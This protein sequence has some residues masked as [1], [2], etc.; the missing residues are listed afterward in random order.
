MEL[1]FNRDC[2]SNFEKVMQIITD[3]QSVLK[4]MPPQFNGVILEQSNNS[5]LIEET[6]ELS[7]LKTKIKQKSIHKKITPT[8]FE[9]NIISGPIKGSSIRIGVQNIKN[10]T[11]IT[12]NANLNL[13]L[14]YRVISSFIK[15]KYS[16]VLEQL[17]DKIVGLVS[18]TDNRNWNESLVNNGETLILSEKYFSLRFTDWWQGDLKQVFVDETYKKM[19]FHDKI[20]LDVGANIADSSIYFAVN[21]AKKVIALEPFPRNFNVGKKNVTNNNLDNKII[22]LLSGCSDKDSTILIDENN[23]GTSHKLKQIDE[24]IEIQTRTLTRVLEEF[25]IDSAVMKL[26]CEG[27]EYDVI[28]GTP[29]YTLQKFESI[30]IEYHDG[31]VNLEKKLKECGF[32][33]KISQNMKPEYAGKGYILANKIL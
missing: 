2:V 8:L 32:A 24:G 21:G 14:K 27:C 4:L 9:I 26:D 28:L 6:I 23:V 11:K 15:K 30:L 33:V 20:V 1:E 22:F 7:V 31:Y 17:V 19:L 29:A 16:I 13:G 25:H 3:Y 5:V 10:K 12:V 18:L